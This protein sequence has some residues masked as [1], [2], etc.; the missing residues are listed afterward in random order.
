MGTPL[1][2]VSQNL[3]NLILFALVI[4]GALASSASATS[5]Y[6]MLTELSWDNIAELGASLHDFKGNEFSFDDFL[7]PLN[8]VL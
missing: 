8:L 5:D 1:V 7:M 3:M 2:I 6:N 4:S